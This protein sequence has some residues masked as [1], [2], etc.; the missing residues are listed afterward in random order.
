MNNWL[1]SLSVAKFRTWSGL[2]MTSELYPCKSSLSS[3][4][5]RPETALQSQTRQK[6]QITPNH[7]LMQSGCSSSGGSMPST[8]EERHQTAKY[9]KYA[10]GER[11]A[12]VFCSRISRG[13]RYK[14]PWLAPPES[15]CRRSGFGHSYCRYWRS[16]RRSAAR[17]WWNGRHARLRI[18]FFRISCG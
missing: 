6:I 9:A 4:G 18:S 7:S 15:T 8:K 16:S 2:D 5:K 3:V 1:P 17:A 12:L 10:N 14:T 11:K 13:S